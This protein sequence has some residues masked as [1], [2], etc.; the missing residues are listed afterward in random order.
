MMPE[1][2]LAPTIEAFLSAYTPR[3]IPDADVDLAVS[4]LVAGGVLKH[5]SKADKSKARKSKAR[6][7][8]AD[9]QTGATPQAASPIG[10]HWASFPDVKKHQEDAAFAGITRIF[11]ILYSVCKQEG[12]ML[13]TPVIKYESRSFHT[14]RAEITGS[15]HKIDAFT[16]PT[17]PS[18]P[19]SDTDTRPATA[20][21]ASNWEPKL[22]DANAKV[23]DVRCHVKL[24]PL[25][26]PDLI[27]PEPKESCRSSNV[28][29]EQRSTE[30]THIQCGYWVII[31]RHSFC[32]AHISTGDDRKIPSIILVLF[33]FPFCQIPC[34]R[35]Q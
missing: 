25:Q 35:H 12:S 11:D 8:N 26:S 19:R 16:T 30:N 23:I 7:P 15:T 6:K 18:V 22:S 29:H 31:A 10:M 9:Q 4:L 17:N 21:L 3:I 14:T 1:I 33:P 2:V 34:Y 28:H 13:V 24:I 27:F 20:D 32:F 5:G